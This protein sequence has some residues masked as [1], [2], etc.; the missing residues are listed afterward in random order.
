MIT[1]RWKN[2]YCLRCIGKPKWSKELGCQKAQV[3]KLSK[4]KHMPSSTFA[5]MKN[6]LDTTCIESAWGL[7]HIFGNRT[8]YKVT[9]KENYLSD[10]KSANQGLLNH[11]KLVGSGPIKLYQLGTKSVHR[12]NMVQHYEVGFMVSDQQ[13]RIQPI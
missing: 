11:L 8:C 4:P 6:F 13:V 1:K 10:L 5:S 9:N 2:T 3:R 7:L 12:F